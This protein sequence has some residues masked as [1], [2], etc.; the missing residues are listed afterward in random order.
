MA[1][2]T[3]ADLIDRYDV[4]LIGDLST[5][6]RETQDRAAVA[7]NGKVLSALEEAS[8]EVDAALLAGGRYSVEQLE[9]LGSK[10][11]AYLKAIVCAL[12]MRSLHERRPGAAD[13]ETMERLVSRATD[14]L[15]KLRSGE[16]VFG[17]DEHIAAGRMTTEGPSAIE[18]QN[19]NDLTA[20]MG[21][22]FP[23]G[24]TRIPKGQ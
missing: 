12:A 1:Y 20:R 16:N 6:D 17:L 8:G 2:A 14:A 10:A 21:R 5:D 18:I 22:Y 7:T 4:D 9:G 23:T 11:T 15:K 13:K 3:G 24:A 19:R